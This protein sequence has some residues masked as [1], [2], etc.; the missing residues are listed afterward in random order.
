MRSGAIGVHEKDVA[1]RRDEAMAHF[2]KPGRQYRERIEEEAAERGLRIG[3]GECGQGQAQGDVTAAAE[4][5]AGRA[6]GKTWA[7]AG[8]AAVFALACA[9]LLA[10]AQ[11]PT[12]SSRSAASM[13]SSSA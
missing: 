7:M 8:M 10:A 6:S 3:A 1:V 5:L 12:Q 2:M 4:R 9:G 13:L 11:T